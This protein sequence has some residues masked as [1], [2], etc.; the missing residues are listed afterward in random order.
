VVVV[1]VTVVLGVKGVVEMKVIKSKE[2][3][4]VDKLW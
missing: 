4:V 1:V 2:G 3:V